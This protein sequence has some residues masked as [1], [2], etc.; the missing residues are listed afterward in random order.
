VRFVWLGVTLTRSFMIFL[1]G[2]VVCGCAGDELCEDFDRESLGFDLQGFPDVDF[3][4]QKVEETQI[5]LQGCPPLL[6]WNS[7]SRFPVERGG[8]GEHLRR[9]VRETSLPKSRELPQYVQRELAEAVQAKEG[10]SSPQG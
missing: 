4:E 6:R 9:R 8:R 2:V 3:L 1:L 10:R 7:P 5:S